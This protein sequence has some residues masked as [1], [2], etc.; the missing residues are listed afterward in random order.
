M[1]YSRIHRRAEYHI[2][3]KRKYGMESVQ[4][5]NK[6]PQTCH[7]LKKKTQPKNYQPSTR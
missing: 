2:I 7:K 6:L 4:T 5:L 1:I 3:K